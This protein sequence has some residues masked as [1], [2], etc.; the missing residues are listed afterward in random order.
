MPEPPA[1]GMLAFRRIEEWVEVLLCCSRPGGR[2]SWQVP[3]WRA[4]LIGAGPAASIEERL[5]RRPVRKVGQ[6]QLLEV[7]RL[8]FV[9]ACDAPLEGPFLFLGGVKRQ[10]HRILYVWAAETDCPSGSFHATP[11]LLARWFDLDAGRGLI[12]ASQRRFLDELEV[13]LNVGRA[14]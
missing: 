12:A 5:R 3:E 7:A 2:G 6:Q 14:G 13:L 9:E 1:A 4:E 10:R 11:C 8:G